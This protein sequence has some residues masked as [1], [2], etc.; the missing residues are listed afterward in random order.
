MVT[1]P[2]V[3]SPPAAIATFQRGPDESA[4]RLKTKNIPSL[5]PAPTV[6][7]P[8]TGLWSTPNNTALATYGQPGDIPVPG[9]DNGDG[10]RDVAVFRPSTATWYVCGIQTTHFGAAGAVPV[11]GGYLSSD[12]AQLAVFRPS[13]AVWYDAGGFSEAWGQT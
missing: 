10:L 1:C 13:K 12:R 5:C 2:F 4:S 11:P 8:A 9:D 3:G 7:H 6:F